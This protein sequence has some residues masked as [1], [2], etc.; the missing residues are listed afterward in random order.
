MIRKRLGTEQ[1]PT[2]SNTLKYAR[3]QVLRQA[4]K[5]IRAKSYFVELFQIIQRKATTTF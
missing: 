3:N 2:C 1:A 5:K 4:K